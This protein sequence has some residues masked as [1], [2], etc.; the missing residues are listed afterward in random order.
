MNPRTLFRLAALALIIAAPF[1]PLGHWLHPPGHSA[2]LAMT[3]RWAP[4]HASVW[5]WALLTALALPGLYAYVAPRV[6]AWALAALMVMFVHLTNAIGGMQSEILVAQPLALHEGTR[7]A[8]DHLLSGTVRPDWMGLLYMV[9]GML[10]PLLFGLVL[11][12]AGGPWRVPG[13]AMMAS[14]ILTFAMFASGNGFWA[15]RIGMALGELAFGWAGLVLWR[16]VS[17]PTIVRE[18]APR[19][20]AAAG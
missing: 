3:T 15:F 8:A 9:P 14:P 7:A 10:G 20:V 19:P 5:L 13:A 18:A 17:A 4:A 2:A 11:V 1:G 12:R 16:Q 6:G